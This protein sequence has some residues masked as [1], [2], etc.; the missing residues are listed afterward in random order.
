MADNQYLPLTISLF[1]KK[2]VVV[3]ETKIKCIAL[4]LEG[5]WVFL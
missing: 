3:A 2:K 1:E 4:K 5:V